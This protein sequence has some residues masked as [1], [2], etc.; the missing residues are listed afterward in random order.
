LIERLKILDRALSRYHNSNATDEQRE[1]KYA[2]L[3]TNFKVL[4]ALAEDDAS[5]KQI[6][7]LKAKM[8]KLKKH[9]KKN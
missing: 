5:L 7:K 2:Q 8:E 9:G 4:E 6:A 1:L 3:A